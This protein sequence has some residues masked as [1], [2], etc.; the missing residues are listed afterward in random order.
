ML[1]M[2]ATLSPRTWSKSIAVA[3]KQVEQSAQGAAFNEETNNLNLAK[4]L[5]IAR[6]ALRRSVRSL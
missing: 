6:T 2:L 4:G 3:S 1:E 5:F